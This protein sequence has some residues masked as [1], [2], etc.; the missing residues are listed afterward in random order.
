MLCRRALLQPAGV[1][2]VC[3]IP[4]QRDAVPRGV[5]WSAPR[6]VELLNGGLGL[7]RSLVA[8]GAVAAGAAVAAVHN[9]GALNVA[10]ACGG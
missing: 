5:E 8:H 4:S 3:V 6:T 1:G 9:V 10:G 2:S 7:L